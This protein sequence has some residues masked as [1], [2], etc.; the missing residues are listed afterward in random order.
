MEPVGHAHIHAT[1][2]DLTR[3][4]L[5]LIVGLIAL[6]AVVAAL[7]P[8]SF[9]ESY[10]W[11]WSKHL[12]SGYYDAPPLIAYAI[13]A[14]TA[15]FGNTPFGVRACAIAFSILTSWAIWRAGSELFG[16]EEDGARASLLFNLTLMCNVELMTGT[17]DAPLIAFSSLF[18]L[19]MVRL[20]TRTEGRWWIAAGIAG[21]LALLSKYTA[22]FLA[23][24]AYVY[25]VL[26]PN[27]RRWL[28]SPLPYAGFLLAVLMFGPDLW[29]NAQHG[30]I[31]FAFQF[32]KAAN[33]HFA[34]KHILG[35][36]AAQLG[37]A[38][39][40][41]LALALFGLAR[42]RGLLWA[43][44]LPTVAFFSFHALQA[45]V[46]G[47]WPCFLYPTLALA[48]AREW[49]SAGNAFEQFCKRWAMWLAALILAVSYVQALFAV[50]PV[51]DPTAHLLASGFPS[52]AEELAELRTREGADAFAATSYALTGWLSFYNPSRAPVTQLNQSERWLAAPLAA[53]SLLQKPMI[54]VAEPRRDRS[55]MLT[56]EFHSVR[57][58]TRL[59][60]LR[61]GR[62]VDRYNVYLLQGFNGKA[63]LRVAN[64]SRSTAIMAE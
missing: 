32:G 57:L 62:V 28:R 60:R 8:L 30:W 11:L 48:A 17:P 33:D 46:E 53:P 24:G 23:A 59:V 13:R 26:S 9:D 6:R 39:P 56:K 7:L 35:F 21:G 34:P 5:Y 58:I 1:G 15:V 20:E 42:G 25:M 3:R 54:Y 51:P 29:W 37:L 45:R 2:G 64:Q 36:V 18:V 12:A 16:H 43:L 38:T 55:K 49:K 44:S 22:L 40:L 61:A 10:Y 52:V 27:A 4:Y 41:I 19:A 47:N 31:S 14:G 50:L 63:A